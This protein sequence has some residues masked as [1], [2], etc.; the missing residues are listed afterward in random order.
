[1]ALEQPSPWVRAPFRP[2]SPCKHTHQPLAVSAS[3]FSGCVL[4]LMWIVEM[5]AAMNGMGAPMDGM[6]APMDGMGAAMHG[7]GAPM[8]ALTRPSNSSAVAHTYS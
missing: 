8:G 4:V 3:S 1:M 2:L 7:M 5:G 6:G